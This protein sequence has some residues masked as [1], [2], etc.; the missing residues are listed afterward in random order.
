MSGRQLFSVDKF[1]DTDRPLL[2]V[3]ADPESIFIQGLAQF[4]HRSLYANV[5]NDRTVTYYTAGISQI[6]PFVDPDDIKINYIP[7]YEDVIVDAEH[8]VSPKEPQEP[9]AFRQRL[10]QGTWTILG[11]TGIV[12][13]L[14]VLVPIGLSAFFINSAFQ[15]IRSQQR[16]KLHEE[17]RS[18]ID[19]AR[20]RIPL[21]INAVRR[22]A[23]DMYENV[24]HAQSQEYLSESYD[25]VSSTSP[26]L[27]RKGSSRSDVDSIQEQKDSATLTFPTLALTQDQFS[28]IEALDNVGFTKHPVHIHNHR[29]SH[30]AIVVRMNKNSFNE[31]K[32]VIKHWLD[33]FEL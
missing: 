7:D 16:I 28:M 9:P 5:V 31:G 29:H 32:V 11:R 13:A 14:T 12:A 24:N 17:G 30:A 22:E 15:S 4:K 6:D 10:A 26:R 2:A 8:P 27:L 19:Y 20:Y 1:R 33:N 23:E 3:L 25:Q 21:M 18:G